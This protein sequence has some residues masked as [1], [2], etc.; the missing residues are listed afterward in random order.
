MSGLVG[1]DNH[2]GRIMGHPDATAQGL[3]VSIYDIGCAVGC[4]FSFFFGERYGRKK[5]ILSG[6]TIMSKCPNMDRTVVIF[7]N[8]T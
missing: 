3:L 5:M 7:V 2:F 8:I 1:A 4:L 6:G